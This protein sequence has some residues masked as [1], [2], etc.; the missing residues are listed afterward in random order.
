MDNKTK[1]RI[2]VAIVAF[3][4]LG[5]T[6]GY[7]LLSAPNRFTGQTT[8]EQ[9]QGIVLINKRQ[10]TPSET[11]AVL[12]AGRAL[13][14]YSYPEDCADCQTDRITLEIFAQKLDRYLILS[15]F[16]G[17][18]KKLQ[19]IGKNGDVKQLNETISEESLINLFCDV[20]IAKPTECILREI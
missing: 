13:I 4:M 20:A 14:E 19:M 7:A 8:G 1:G 6:A 3:I 18:E 2:F 9:T 11:L 10:L 5:S 15:E 17:T 16:S 12:N